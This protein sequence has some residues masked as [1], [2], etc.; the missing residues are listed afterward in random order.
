MAPSGLFVVNPAYVAEWQI[1]H[2][3]GQRIWS[4]G[5]LAIGGDYRLGSL[6][7]H[8]YR[9]VPCTQA[10]FAKTPTWRRPRIPRSMLRGWIKPKYWFIHFDIIIWNVN[11]G[12]AEM[13]L[14]NMWWFQ[15]QNIIAAT[16]IRLNGHGLTTRCGNGSKNIR[17]D[18]VS[19]NILSNFG[20]Y[21]WPETLGSLFIQL[22]KP[23]PIIGC[24]SE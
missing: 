3:P 6:L 15:G 8:L 24:L 18:D 14:S 11:P 21:L 5:F 4:L 10:Y 23:A 13:N 2:Y 19:K 17:Y 20:H 1:L 12:P 22:Y 7:I 16:L 9:P